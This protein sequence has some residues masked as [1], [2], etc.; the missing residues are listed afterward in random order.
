MNLKKFSKQLSLLKTYS[1]NTWKALILLILGLTF[2]LAVTVHTHNSYQRKLNAEFA[3]VCHEIETKIGIRLHAHAE[4][5]RAGSAFFAATDTVTRQG[6]KDFIENVKIHK[7][8]P[9]T[10]G[11]GFSLI[12][13]KNQ[14]QQ[15]IQKIREEGFPDYTVKPAG[16][17]ALYTSII[18]LE[19]FTGR[20]L[21]AFGYDMFSEPVRRKAMEKS[22]DDDIAML[23]GKVILIQETDQDLQPGTL[24]YVPVYRNKMPVGSVEQRRAA[25]IGWVY[26]PY[27]M[28]DLMHGILGRWDIIHQDRIHL[29][30]FDDSISNQSLLYDSQSDKTLKHD[31]TPSR[32]LCLPVEFKTKKWILCFSQSEDR[33]SYFH[34]GVIL[35]FISGILISFLL[36]GLFLSLTNTRA[37]ALQSARNLSIKLK[38]SEI[39][40]KMVADYAY[41]WE[42]WEGTDNQLLYMSPSC[43]RISG[44]KPDEFFSDNKLLQKI[45]HPGDLIM[46]DKHF[47]RVHSSE[48]ARVIDEIDF[49]II[50][51]DGSVSHIGH[52]CTPVFDDNGTYLGRRISNRDITSRK[53]GE[54]LL[55]QTRQNYEIFFNTIDDFLFVLDE[56][57]N[58]IHTNNTVINR[59]GYTWEE[60]SGKSVLMIHP[61]ERR[62]EAGRIVSE[63]LMGI[64]EFCPVPVITKSGITIPVET[65]VKK[66][67]WDGKPVIFGVSKDISS[68]KLS[69]EK[70]SKLFHINPSACGLSD[71]SNHHYLEV[72]EAFY[73]L[74]GF[75]KDEVIGKTATELGILSEETIRTIM[76]SADKH[77]NVS[78][79]KTI[80][81][82]KNGTIKH[83]LLS[84]ENI[85]VQDKKY[86]FT[87]VNDVTDLTHANNAMAISET[88]YRRLFES[89]KDGI[90]ILDAETGMIA[91]VNPYLVQLLG[92]SKEQ[93]IKK[94]IWEIGFFKDVVANR[95]KF[96][97]LQQNQYVRYENLPLET[98]FGKRINVEFISNLYLV[99]EQKVIQC[100]IRDITERRLADEAL[101]KSEDKYRIL[102]ETMPNGFYR[103]TPEGYYVDANP[104]LLNMLG[105]DSLEELSKVYIPT[106][107]YVKPIERD[108][109]N[110]ENEG[111]VDS[112]EFYR[113]KTKDGRI[114]SIEDNARYI[115]DEHGNLLFHEGICRD[116][117]DRKKAE[118]EIQ[119]KNQELQKLNATKDKFFSI[120]AHDLKSPFNSIMG[121]SELLVEQVS[122][123]N[124]KGIAKYAGIIFN[125]SQRAVDL[126]M[127]LMEWS[128]SQTGRM[129][130]IPDTIEMVDFISENIIMFDEIARQKSIVIKKDLPL[131]A[132]V[133][134]DQDMIN[135]VL[136]NLLS[137]A[138][139]FT[140]PGGEILVSIN[141]KP[142]EMTVS[143]KDSGI[144]IPA[145]RIDKLFQIDESYS[146]PGTNNERGTG[147]GLILCKEFVEKHG[148]RIWAESVLG[149]GSTFSFTLPGTS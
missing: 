142:N 62:D 42:Y 68:L 71:L 113:L 120:I 111:Y 4:L 24:M 36:T 14:L 57:A 80:L 112:L 89:A 131:H 99:N 147:L 135:T 47:E 107:I 66:G 52:L 124:L 90:L 44:Y 38:E 49:R 136:R 132:A 35:V 91:D 75:D 87:V 5:L 39:K 145:G 143:V 56:Q 17:R 6:W 53:L 26:S 83:V 84:S 51:K 30:V 130:F 137:N 121:F 1:V 148:G 141:Q 109:F 60:L 3:S 31:D 138:I 86:R 139:K 23:S 119:F 67:I 77:G 58:I 85:F 93:F 45:L 69:E 32:I 110:R 125:S 134:A 97:E 48:D 55:T 73:N 21:R 98:A 127:N 78:N 129:D 50:K 146:T 108:A 27:R 37:S 115:K 11:V 28:N 72:N 54:D 19:P 117:T 122:E 59:L 116:I 128:R 34:V 103:S 126:L 94:T 64:T 92:Y 133:F 101:K 16:D 95:D 12:I 144:G 88:R 149:N 70:F 118:Q 10:Q 100:N 82:T 105:Y 46:L 25:I 40:F 96:T 123:N 13:P 65:T 9:G 43:E 7:N 15:H 79:A 29:Q 61:P 81:K 2:T 114:I 106:D 102:F 18:Y 104:A 8:L 74:F 20:N 140:K 41:D 22:C 33:F 63:M 76:L